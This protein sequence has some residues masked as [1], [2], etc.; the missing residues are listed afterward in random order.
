MIVKVFEISK[1]CNA[2]S[3]PVVVYV[4]QRAKEKVN[5]GFCLQLVMISEQMLL[6]TLS[7]FLNL[8]VRTGIIN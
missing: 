8:I 3:S 6:S 2:G 4:S 5:I 1:L 7:I